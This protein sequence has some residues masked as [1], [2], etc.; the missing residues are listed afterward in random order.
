[1]YQTTASVLRDTVSDPIPTNCN[2][3]HLLRLSYL[4]GMLK[5]VRIA[6]KIKKMSRFGFLLSVKIYRRPGSSAEFF[7]KINLT[8]KAWEKAV[9]ELSKAR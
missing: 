6:K 8:V 3:Q 9:Q 7:T 5:V 4:I 2:N 1:M